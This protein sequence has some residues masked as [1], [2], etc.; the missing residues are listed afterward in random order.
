MLLFSLN[1]ILGSANAAENTDRVGGNIKVLENKTQPVLKKNLAAAK[2]NISVIIECNY[3]ALNDSPN[4]AA[5]I[6]ANRRWTTK[7]ASLY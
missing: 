5:D 4:N 6:Q 3:K 7:M 2:N 1:G